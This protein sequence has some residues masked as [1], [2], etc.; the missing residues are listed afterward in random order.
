MA[1]PDIKW[2]AEIPLLGYEILPEVA[3]NIVIVIVNL[4]NT[5][6]QILE[7]VE[8]TRV[9]SYPFIFLHRI[10]SVSLSLSH[11]Y[12]YLDTLAPVAN[13]LDSSRGFCNYEM[14]I[15]LSPNRYVAMLL[16]VL[17]CN[18]LELLREILSFP[19]HHYIY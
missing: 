19:F 3:E 14:Y 9:R 15:S 6:C 10:L 11:L 4:Q 8:F 2:I 5:I 16:P 17:H 13:N 7:L 18:G 12:C 1:K